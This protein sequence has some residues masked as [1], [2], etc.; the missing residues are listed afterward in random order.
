MCKPRREVS[1]EKQSCWHLVMSLV[2]CYGNP[3]KLTH[4]KLSIPIILDCSL[5]R[6]SSICRICFD[7]H[8]AL[9]YCRSWVLWSRVFHLLWNHEV[10][11]EVCAWKIDAHLKSQPGLPRW[12]TGK[13]I[14][15]QCGR[16]SFDPWSGSS[17]NPLQY[18]RLKNPMNRGAW[19][20]AVH[21]VTKNQT[22][23]SDL[24]FSLYIYET[25]YVIFK[26]FIYLAVPGLVPGPRIK[27]LSPV[28]GTQ[29]LN[30]QT[31]REVFPVFSLK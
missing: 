25:H 6:L 24:H 5:S 23:L 9:S 13:A 15:L 7:K 18:S 10:S 11:S 31:G 22:W 1:G 28:L 3:G 20:A 8:D 26:T 16:P 30:Q 4:S 2:F 19:R 29:K 14:C 27:L 12:I 17:C 21:G